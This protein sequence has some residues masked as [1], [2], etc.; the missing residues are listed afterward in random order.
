MSW[1][2]DFFQNERP[3]LNPDRMSHD[4]LKAAYKKLLSDL[5][6]MEPGKAYFFAERA[7]EAGQLIIYGVSESEEAPR[8]TY[9]AGDPFGRWDELTQSVVGPDLG[10]FPLKGKSGWCWRAAGHELIEAELVPFE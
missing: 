1:L 2:S 9:S 5:D 6:K 10:F 7:P 3:D 4:E 8:L